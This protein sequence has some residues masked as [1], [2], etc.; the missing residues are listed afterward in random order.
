MKRRHSVDIIFALALFCVFA[1]S[2][3][4]VL[5]NGA[6]VYRG[7]AE[8]LE[9]YYEERSCLSY[10]STKIHHF[11]TAGAVSLTAYGDG[12]ALLLTEVIDGCEYGTVIYTHEGMIM[13]LFTETPISFGPEAGSRILPAA[14][15]HFSW[16][17]EGRLLRIACTGASG[18]SAEISVALSAVGEGAPA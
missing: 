13:E 1:A 6:G 4:L 9:Q 10:L 17:A 7:V 3:L 8:R 12:E 14:G 5:M 2:V 15:L 18:N 16:L 11:D